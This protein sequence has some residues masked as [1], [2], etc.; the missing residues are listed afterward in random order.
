MPK[1]LGLT[2]P[3]L[4]FPTRLYS[5]VATMPQPAAPASGRSVA[6]ARNMCILSDAFAVCNV[7]RQI[8]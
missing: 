3:S 5:I 4:P 8:L 2:K 1:G 6:Y 7:Y